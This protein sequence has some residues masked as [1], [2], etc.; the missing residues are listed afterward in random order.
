MKES[1]SGATNLPFLVLLVLFR[2][3]I[4]LF[5]CYLNPVYQLPM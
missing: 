5:S 4:L 3:I 2:N 1:I